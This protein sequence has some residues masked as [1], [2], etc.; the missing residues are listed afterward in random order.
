MG[1]TDL[2]FLKDVGVSYGNLTAIDNVSFSMHEGEIRILTGEHGAGKTTLAKVVG[3]V[4]GADKGQVYIQGVPVLAGKRMF[5]REHFE[6]V[7]KDSA[8]I[9]HFS[10]AKN[11][12]LYGGKGNYFYNRE[13]E[14]R[15]IQALLDH[16]EV[17]LDPRMII[18]NLYQSDQNLVSILLHLS[19]SP[20]LL[21]LD[22]TLDSLSLSSFSKVTRIIKLKQAEGMACLII[23]HDIENARN[24][25]DSISIMKR[26]TILATESAKAIDALNIIK[27]T[28]AN[29]RNTV[30]QSEA[31][32]FYQLLKYNEAIIGTLPVN[33]LILDK[34]YIIKLINNS[35]LE[36]F[37]FPGENR[38]GSSFD[39]LFSSQD[40]HLVGLIHESVKREEKKN[41][42]NQVLH[43]GMVTKN[44]NITVYPITVTSQVIG[45]MVLLFDTTETVKLREQISFMDKMSSINILSAG[46]AHEINN[47]LGII[48]NCLD[49]LSSEIVDDE[50]KGIIQ[51]VEDE[52]TSISKIISSLVSYSS[53]NVKTSIRF[54]VGKIIESVYIFFKY[55]G[56]EH[57]IR[58]VLHP[59]PQCVYSFAKDADLKQILLNILKNAVEEMPNGGTIDI[60]MDI[61]P[62]RPDVVMIR[63][64]DDGPSLD[65]KNLNDVF[66]PF[67]STKAGEN[68]G[69]GLYICY[70]LAK[71]NNGTIEVENLQPHGCQFTVVFP[72]LVENG[73]FN[74]TVDE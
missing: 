44:V 46:I 42:L 48:T 23:S 16:W 52:I 73:Q 27:L 71:N 56:K 28:Y 62:D 4:I 32:D 6:Y 40:S 26:G 14:V 50:Q 1:K 15:K 65:L 22:E 3:G 35:A 57:G 8:L 7:P 38:S 13:N 21:I 70:N 51:E 58:V 41:F 64:K 39:A 66:L 29:F 34:Q 17:S 47:P 24:L 67:Y 45:E 61:F 37:G 19:R 12:Y 72:R 9:R 60:C 63:I 33:I 69:L 18:G 36:F 25:A 2:V 54:N 55:Y 20:K 10:I 30:S 59:M 53:Q 49:Y 11:F 31:R 74:T 5:V 43:I 68:M